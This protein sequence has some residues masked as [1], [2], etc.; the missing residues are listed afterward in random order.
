M[1]HPFSLC[2]RAY[3]QNVIVPLTFNTRHNTILR[4]YTNIA[5]S[6]P[7]FLAWVLAVSK[8]V[9][10]ILTLNEHENKF[11]K[12]VVQMMLAGK[13]NPHVSKCLTRCM[14]IGQQSRCMH[15]CS[16]PWI[17]ILMTRLLSFGMLELEWDKRIG[18]F[19]LSYG[20]MAYW[21]QFDNVHVVV[22]NTWMQSMDTYEP[23]L[24]GNLTSS[25]IA[26]CLSVLI[27]NRVRSVLI[28]SVI[29]GLVNATVGTMKC[30]SSACVALV[31]KSLGSSCSGSP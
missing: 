2:R 7:V 20:G 29:V 23:S 12:Y 27:D 22:Q 8:Y 13:R 10:I 26:W 14:Y 9:H 28:G 30:F 21:T 3:D 15:V 25:L 19:V 17:K 1:W 6:L 5:L 4:L 18:W 24:L 16:Y 11:L 31:T